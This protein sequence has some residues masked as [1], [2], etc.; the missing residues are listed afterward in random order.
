MT[1]HDASLDEYRAHLT[2]TADPGRNGHGRPT[3]PP[4]RRLEMQTLSD[5]APERVSWLWL[6]RIPRGKLTLVVG[7]PGVGKSH[8]TLD[9][10]AR[11]TH[12]GRWPDGA[13]IEDPG[14]VVLLSAEDGLADTIRPRL[15]AA[16][17]DV[18]R[19]V[20]VETATWTDPETGRAMHAPIRLDRDVALLERA[21]TD[22]RDCRLA[23]IDPITAYLGA[24]DSHKNAEV[25]ALLAALAAMAGRTGLAVAAVTHPTKSCDR[26]AMYRAQGSIAFAAAARAVWCAV[27]DRDDPEGRRRLWLPIKSNLSRDDSGLAYTLRQD[28]GSMVAHVVWERDPVTTRADDAMAQPAGRPGPAPV[29]QDEAADWLRDVLRDGPMPA[30]ELRA[31]AKRDGLSWRTVERVRTRLGVMARR[32]G[33][34]GSADQ[35]WVWELPATSSTET[36]SAP[37][38]GYPGDLGGLGENAGNARGLDHEM[39]ETARFPVCSA[40][41]GGLDPG[42]DRQRGEL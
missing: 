22:L 31:A 19:V 26:P 16:G 33:A 3:D 5:V 21:I 32:V 20:A 30:S 34:V 8:L 27:H 18:T 41:P 35:Q 12:H 36:A 10:A 28:P 11:V 42:P 40:E 1:N 37:I 13:P 4:V 7:D 25:R 24:A 29:A 15:D 23:V 17:A 9:I 39:A 38:H 14:S 6:G 2:G